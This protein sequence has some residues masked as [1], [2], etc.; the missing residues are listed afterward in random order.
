[1][2][3]IKFKKVASGCYELRNKTSEDSM[4]RITDR[5]AI[6]VTEHNRTRFFSFMNCWN[7]SAIGICYGYSEDNLCFKGKARK[8]YKDSKGY[9]FMH[10]RQKVRI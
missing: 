2:K 6:L 1:M 3:E 7:E 8:I 10:E 9:Y 5:K 4:D